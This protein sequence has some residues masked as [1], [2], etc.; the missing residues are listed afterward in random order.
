M[1]AFMTWFAALPAWLLNNPLWTILIIC[2]GMGGWLAITWVALN[3]QD[4]RD[5]RRVRADRRRRGL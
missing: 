3:V 1:E 5:A 2:L 4:R